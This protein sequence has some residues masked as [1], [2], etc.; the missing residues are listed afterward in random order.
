MKILS[1][2]TAQHHEV[3]SLQ[4]GHCVFTSFCAYEG[5]ILFLDSHLE[6]LVAG[7]DFLFPS[8]LWTKKIAEI[9]DYVEDQFFQLSAE[10]KQGCYARLNIFDDNIYLQVR[11]SQFFADSLK[12]TSGKKIKTLDLCPSFLKLPNYV[13]SDLEVASAQMRGFDDVLFFDQFNNVTEATTSN[14]LMVATDGTILTPPPSSIILDGILRKKL[15]LKL[16][17]SGFSIMERSISKSELLKAEEIWLT[18][19]IRGIRK[20]SVFEE[21]ILTNNSMY[22]K[23]VSIFGRYGENYE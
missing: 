18:N 5:K 9:K 6:R 10:M 14:L 23:A 2:E 20:V 3:A 1:K 4:R 21:K 12:L 8:V 16:K 13:E 17:E 22:D 19:S 11:K 15:F 7:A